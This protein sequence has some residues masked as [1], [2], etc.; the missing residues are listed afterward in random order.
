VTK[1]TVLIQLRTVT[2][3][4]AYKSWEIVLLNTT[5]IVAVFM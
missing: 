1:V 2:K 5:I 3:V 4:A